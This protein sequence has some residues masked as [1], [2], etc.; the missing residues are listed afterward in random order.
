MLTDLH[1]HL[2]PD[3]L[4]ASAGEYYSRANAARYREAA[5]ERGIVELGV[6]EH[7]Y[8]FRQALEVWRHPFWERYAHDDLDELLRRL[9]RRAQEEPCAGCW[10]SCRGFAESMYARPRLRQWRE[11]YHSVKRR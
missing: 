8:R 6:S 3:D 9:Q 10:T 2:R 5:L 11:F 7:V 1:L 4:D